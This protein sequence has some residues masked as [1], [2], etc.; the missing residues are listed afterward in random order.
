MIRGCGRLEAMLT[1]LPDLKVIV[2]THNLVDT[3]NSG[4]GMF[5]FF[6]DEFHPSDKR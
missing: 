5:S 3:V 2:I 1:L 6:G 4:L